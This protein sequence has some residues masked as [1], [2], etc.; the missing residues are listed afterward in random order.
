MK[1]VTAII[2]SIFC[3]MTILTACGSNSSSSSSSSHKV[4]GYKMYSVNVK[5]IKEDKDDHEFTVTG[6]T[7]APDGS[8]IYASSTDTSYIEYG[9]NAASSTGDI[10][11]WAKV[12]DGKFKAN[13]DPNDLYYGKFKEG[14]KVSA[15]IFAIKE[16]DQGMHSSYKFTKSQMNKIKAIASVSDFKISAE[17]AKYLNDIS[18]NYTNSDDT[19]D[20]D[21]TDTSDDTSS[22]DTSSYQNVSYDS[23]ARKPDDYDGEKVTFTG[24]VLQVID[25]NDDGEDYTELRIAVDGDYKNVIFAALPNYELNG[26]RVLE[27]DLVTVYGESRGIITY[28]SSLNSDISVPGMA[29]DKITDKG[30]APSGYGY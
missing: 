9:E 11:E 21:T 19:D 30:K 3:L 29:V 13:V 1:K 17:I 24:K 8:K 6:T 18:S 25:D 16:F 15:Y 28:T 4:A 14:Q 27:D 20:T 12:K 26:S 7:D 2:F 22:D 10:D 23:I 5:S